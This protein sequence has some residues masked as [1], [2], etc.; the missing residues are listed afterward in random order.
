MTLSDHQNSLE[1]DRGAEGE[2]P[3]ESPRQAP[4]RLSAIRRIPPEVP[5]LVF[6]VLLSV[7]LTWPVW[8]DITH[9]VYG[10]PS[11]NLGAMWSWWWIRNS[12]SFGASA[13]FSPLVGYP[14][15]TPVALISVEFILDISVRFLLLFMSQVV[16]L[17]LI[18][19]S[20]FALSGVTMYYLVRHITG[21]RRVAFFGGFAYL[22]S[23]Y[24]ALTATFFPNL[25]LTQW[26]PLYILML[27]LFVKK[28]KLRNAVFLALSAILVIGTS[29]HYG[30]FM[31][32]FTA[33]FLLGR[34]AYKRLHLRHLLKTGSAEKL[35]PIVINRKTVALTLLVLLALFVVFV[36]LLF[37]SFGQPGDDPNWP[38]RPT[39]SNMRDLEMAKAGSASPLAYLLPVKE[40][41]F[42]GWLT[43]RWAPLRVSGWE[44]FLYLG[45]TIM[46]LAMYAVIV[47]RPVRRSKR[48][49]DTCD[50]KDAGLDS[51]Y[52]AR[53]KGLEPSDTRAIVWGLVLAAAVAFILSMPPYF[54]VGSRKIPLPSMILRYAAPLLRWYMRFGVVVI[55]CFIL[56]ACIG[57]ARL[58]QRTSGIKGG[59]LLAALTVFLFLE[60][61]LVPPF[62]YFTIRDTPPGVFKRVAAMDDMTAQ[63]IYP[64]YE[65]G[66]FASQL[67][68]YYQTDTRKPMLNGGGPNSDGEA[69]R[70]TVFNPFNPETPGILSRFGF[71][72][73]VYLDKR[74]EDY[75]GTGKSEREIEHLPP[76][77]ELFERVKDKDSFG[78]GYIFRVTAEKAALVPI[79]RG[80][81]TAPHIDEGRVTVRL[82]KKAGIISIAN[83]TGE[84]VE[85]SIKIPIS[86]INGVHEIALLDIQSVLWTVRLSGDEST[87]IVLPGIMVPEE[88]LELGL[89]VTGPSVI[90][91]AGEGEIF[92]TRQAT[93]KIGDVALG[94]AR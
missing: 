81:I 40:N 21:D 14:F 3:V 10:V 62:R 41:K 35:E 48:Q 65:S 56:L 59:V 6:F 38:T 63:V 16:V 73:V 83:Y 39:A 45:L 75:A 84:D 58:L 91:D 54:T 1:D 18:I 27:L 13:S 70:R 32:A 2:P 47:V 44:N 85:A 33:S 61:T 43:R 55:I 86:N 37:S 74:F 71:T 4:A 5:V 92:G 51:V 78:S 15:G 80:D 60:M 67:Y 52:E 72:H 25:A 30:L 29:V 34:F 9:K 88:G 64:A 28:P 89:S 76:G 93:I 66:A 68:M 79:Y 50:A 17:N 94:P 90:L 87:E 36:P 22:I 46:A 19:T 31:V 53:L 77:F 8:R 42:L 49:E 11:D 24:H 23:A 7:F 12:A 82:M 26:M 57:L 69:L 20:S